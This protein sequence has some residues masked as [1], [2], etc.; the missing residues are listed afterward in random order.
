[1]TEVLGDDDPSALGAVL[2]GGPAG[3]RHDQPDRTTITRWTPASTVLSGDETHCCSETTPCWWA[4]CS[5][6]TKGLGN[7]LLLAGASEASSDPLNH[8]GTVI[9]WKASDDS[10]GHAELTVFEGG[11]ETTEQAEPPLAVVGG[12]ESDAVRDAPKGGRLVY[13]ADVVRLHGCGHALQTEAGEGR[14]LAVRI[15]NADTG[16]IADEVPAITKSAA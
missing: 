16:E 13:L 3:G 8:R 5:A 11:G 7:V 10:D 4:K 15:R 6:R 9:W 2:G 12:I 1:M 14:L